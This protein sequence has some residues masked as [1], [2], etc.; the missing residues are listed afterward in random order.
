MSKLIRALNCFVNNA[1]KVHLTLFSVFLFLAGCAEQNQQTTEPASSKV[2]AQI[3][4]PIQLKVGEG[5]INPLGY[6]EQQPRFSWKIPEQNKALFQSAYQIQVATSANFLD[7]Q[8]IW[9]SK[10]VISDNNAWIDYQGKKLLSRQKIYWRVK[11]WD[12]NDR[13]SKWSEVNHLE[14]GLLNNDDW[15]AKWI[16][17]PETGERNQSEVKEGRFN[18]PDNLYYRPQYLRTTFE[19]NKK[20]TKA[21]LYITSKGVFKPFINGEQVSQDVMTP[22]WTPYHKRIETLTTM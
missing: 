2:V 12:E 9:D 19:V 3:A 18:A 20:V 17:H 6:Y 4:A 22:G 21:R 5:F 10:K 1:I 8:V 14:L 13:A 7:N 15:Q 11:M 16:G